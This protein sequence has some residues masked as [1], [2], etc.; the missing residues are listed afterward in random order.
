MLKK[1]VSFVIVLITIFSCMSCT[2]NKESSLN[3]NYS[4]SIQSSL[5][6]NQ[7]SFSGESSEDDSLSDSSQDSSS[8]EIIERSI[9]ICQ[10]TETWLYVEESM[11]LE[12]V[13]EN[14]TI[15]WQLSQQNLGCEIS[16]NGLLTAGKISGEIIVQAYLKEDSNINDSISLTVV[17]PMLASATALGTVHNNI[18]QENNFTY[19]FRTYFKIREYGEF[20]YSFYYDNRQDTTWWNVANS[21]ANRLGGEFTI[22]TAYFSDGGTVSDG[23]VCEDSSVAITFNGSSQ[24][25]VASGEQFYSDAVTLNIPEGHFLAFTWAIKVNLSSGPSVP[26]TESTFA[27]CYKK[28][29][30]YASQESDS[31]FVLSDS[32]FGTQ[33]LVAPNKILY[34]RPKGKNLVF[35]G[36]SI[37]QGVATKKDLYE[38]WVARVAD[39]LPASHSVWN[40]GSG[41]ATLGNLA[42]KDVWMEKVITADELFVC[43]GV[44]DLGGDLSL[45]S[46]QSMINSVTSHVKDK[47]PD[48]IITLLT[49]PP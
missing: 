33:V 1:F 24:K 30:D 31:G 13:C 15:V 44:N 21:Y 9:S 5:E 45:A 14:G 32:T 29:G 22:L 8:E 28:S 17:E 40:L 25:K 10:P 41:W 38:F 26:F 20:E 42:T 43:L 4:G 36:D 2:I 23:A 37:T 47:N 46:Y 49:I 18:I 39:Q 3:D 34:K 35:V 19:T 48:C 27:S 16:N 12:A 11:Q 7:D 6:N